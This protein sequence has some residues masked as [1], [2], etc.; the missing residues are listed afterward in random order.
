MPQSDDDTRLM[1]REDDGQ[2]AA[3]VDPTVLLPQPAPSYDEEHGSAD[4]PTLGRGLDRLDR[5]YQE[6]AKQ[7][8][9][10]IPHISDEDGSG[11]RIP[12]EGRS[13]SSSR[14]VLALLL[15]VLMVGAIAAAG[16][17]GLE[18]W[19]GKHVPN[20]VGFT[21]ARAVSM[22]DEKGL[23]AEVRYETADDGIGVVLRQDPETGVRLAVG[24]TVTVTV[25]QSRT[26]PEVLGLT[27][28]EA[29]SLL[30]TAG[31]Q[32]VQVVGKAST[33][34]EGTVVDV[35]P[36]VG[37]A[38]SA[39]EAVVLYVSAKPQVP[40]VI[41]KGRVEAQ[42]IVEEAGFVASFVQ[43]ASDQ[44]PN[45]V[46]ETVPAPGEKLD[47]GA[48]VELRVSEPMPTDPLHLAEYFS[49]TP[50]NLAS[51]LYDKGFWLV[52]ASCGEG[53]Y[54]E[55]CYDSDTRGS[56]YFSSRPFSHAL[57][58][59]GA[60]ADVLADGATFRG[61]RWEVPEAMLPAGA[62]EVSEG[63]VRSLMTTCGFSNLKDSCTQADVQ[64]PTN[65]PVN[66]AKFRCAYGETGEFAWTVLIAK[67]S[68]GVRAAVT[69]APKSL[70]D[71]YDLAPYGGSACDMVAYVDMYTE[72]PEAYMKDFAVPGAN[73]KAADAGKADS[74]AKEDDA[75]KEG[76]DSKE[77]ESTDV[78]IDGHPVPNG[79]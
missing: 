9:V 24:S 5:A 37:Q 21:E 33:A 75:T 38:F 2:D 16:A 56:L 62:T 42:S 17:Y 74:T 59:D 10:S 48:T 35:H 15:V 6:P 63:A 34:E 8:E 65:T 49:K 31:A 51:Y 14:P 55:A 69:C 19:G 26:M 57:R 47:P 79:I 52:S 68:T 44:E 30:A 29:M 1:G 64:L 36:G 22:L 40:D 61:M 43:V 7:R 25:A 45:T 28:D 71:G 12:G 58:G 23:V 4:D 27:Q 3:K 70:Y 53:D 54:A 60:Y 13:R 18:L 76:A 32:N 39:H 66:K 46:V 11:Y 78:T 41:G 77:Q 73:D 72:W 67:E 20:V 50:A